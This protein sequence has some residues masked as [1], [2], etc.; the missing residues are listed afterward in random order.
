MNLVSDTLSGELL[1]IFAVSILDAAI[2][3]WMALLWYRRSVFRLMKAPAAA[4]EDDVVPVPEPSIAVDSPVPGLLERSVQPVRAG[5]AVTLPQSSRRLA[6]AYLVGTLAYSAVVTIPRIY[7]LWPLPPG[8]IAA[9]VWINVWPIVPALGLLLVLPWTG[10]LRLG[11][12]FLLCGSVLVMLV[13]FAGQIARGSFNSAPFTNVYWANRLLLATAYLPALVLLFISWRRIRAVVAMTLAATLF[14]GLGLPFFRRAVVAILEADTLKALM[15]AFAGT[16]T[17]EAAF[18]SIYMLVALPVGW[19][20]W[21]VLRRL[22]VAFERKAFSDIQLVV[23]C[24]FAIVTMELI[25][26]QLAGPFGLRGIAMGLLAFAVYRASVEMMLRIRPPVVAAQAEDPPRRL[27]LLRVFGHQSRTER[28]FDYIAQHWRFRGPVQLIAGADLAMR[29]IDPGDVLAFVSGRLRNQYVASPDE[30]P[31]RIERL[32]MRPDPDGRFRIN[33]LYCLH[34]TWKPTLQAL[35]TVTDAVVVDVRGFSRKSRGVLYE[36]QQIVTT[37]ATDRI[38]LIADHATD[39]QL[40]EETLGRA[41]TQVFHPS[42]A[43]HPI[44]LVKVNRNSPREL[45]AV[46]N[47]LLPLGETVHA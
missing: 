31:A 43:A 4:T 34:D 9:Q 16:T 12:V 17:V 29:T 32:D 36:L 21:R 15:L 27:L 8:G 5:R 3:S 13:T 6:V 20:G 45:S 46:M 23:D 10:T 11:G 14:F 33:E 26:M 37:I 40:L 38:V 2:L 39:E 30:I 18:Y 22:A 47:H 25:A 24:W 1:Y 7:E 41:W 19:F 44:L 42:G 35:L 28:L